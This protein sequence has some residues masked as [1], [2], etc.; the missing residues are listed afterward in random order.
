M[1]YAESFILSTITWLAAWYALRDLNLLAPAVV[2]VAAAIWAYTRLPEVPGVGAGAVAAAALGLAVTVIGH[3]IF[4]Y[5]RIEPRPFV[6]TPETMRQAYLLI[7][8][9]HVVLGV[10]AWAAGCVLGVLLR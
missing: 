3:S 10:L 2:L 7:G 1:I 5:V 6:K 8:M 4:Y 9:F